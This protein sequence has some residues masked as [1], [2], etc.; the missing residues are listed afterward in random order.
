MLEVGSS[1]LT[2]NFQSLTSKLL[3]FLRP[4]IAV[5]AATFPSFLDACAVQ[6]SADHRVTQADVLDATSAQEYDCVFLEVVSLSW[7]VCRNFNAVGEANTSDLADSGVWLLWSL[8][9]YF[10]AYAALE[11]SGEKDR[12]VLKRVECTRECDRL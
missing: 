4:L 6:D 9:G 11:W 12:S 2:S 7:N 1:D 8:C 3:R 10:D 5:L